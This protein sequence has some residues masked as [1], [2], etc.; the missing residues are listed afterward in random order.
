MSYQSG[1]LRSSNRFSGAFRSDD[2]PS[3]TGRMCRARRKVT[4]KV[5]RTGPARNKEVGC[6]DCGWHK[7]V[8]HDWTCKFVTRRRS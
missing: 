8:G 1:I 5:Y 7:G 6:S 4:W 2:R 3:R